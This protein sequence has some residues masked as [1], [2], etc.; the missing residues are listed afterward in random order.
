M[1]FMC[2]GC[3]KVE[4]VEDAIRFGN[5]FYCDNCANKMCKAELCQKCG[6]ELREAI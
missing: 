3:F 6:I 2:N 1:R 4:D 5:L